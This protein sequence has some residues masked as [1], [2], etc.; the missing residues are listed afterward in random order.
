VKLFATIL[1][2]S[3]MYMSFLPCGDDLFADI[4]SAEVAHH[5]PPG[6][7]PDD[8]EDSD[9]C[10]PFCICSCC[11]THIVTLDVALTA[12]IIS[13]LIPIKKDAEPHMVSQEAVFECWHPPN[14]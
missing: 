3:I 7:S 8:H 12:D 11:Q 2:I 9:F 1:A 4:C 13:I 5:H 6:E 10:S 14:V